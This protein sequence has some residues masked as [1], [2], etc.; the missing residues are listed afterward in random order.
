MPLSSSSRQALLPL[1][2]LFIAG[3]ALVL[4]GRGWLTGRGLNP[5]ALLVANL[6]FFVLSLLVHRML[7]KAA[8]HS[9]PNV[10]VRTVMGGTMLK[11][12]VVL[13]AVAVYAF[14]F[15]PFFSKITVFAAM[16]W[17]LVYLVVEVRTSVRL[18]QS[19]HA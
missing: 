17:Y 10:F 1:I 2:M 4:T 6:L 9:N 3:N 7:L 8:R 13:V 19:G 14:A 16:L 18:N 12:A 11:M 15:R 5:D